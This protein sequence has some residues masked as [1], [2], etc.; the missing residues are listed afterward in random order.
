LFL[1]FG[2]G[3]GAHAASLPAEHMFQAGWFVVGLCT[4][5]LV[6]HV[7]RTRKVPFWRAPASAIVILSTMMALLVG[8]FLILSPLHKAFDFGILPAAYW[9]GAVIIVLVYLG[10]VEWTKAGYLKRGRPWL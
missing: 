4:Q 10:M 2:L 5:S 8:L 7:L 9:P 6:I 3:V 1:W